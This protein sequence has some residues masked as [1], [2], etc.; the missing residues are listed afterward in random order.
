[1]VRRDRLGRGLAGADGEDAENEGCLRHLKS[2]SKN[3]PIFSLDDTNLCQK[4]FT[5]HL[6]CHLIDSIF[7]IGSPYWH[8]IFDWI[9]ILTVLGL[10]VGSF[11]LGLCTLIFCSNVYL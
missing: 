7:S 8:F 10:L 1:M 5:Q 11:I 2:V 6:L 3:F 4:I 9:A